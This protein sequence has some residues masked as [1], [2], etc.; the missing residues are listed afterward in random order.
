MDIFTTAIISNLI[1][2]PPPLSTTTT[3]PTT[4]TAGLKG[5]NF[6]IQRGISKLDFLDKIF[7][8]AKQIGRS[9]DLLLFQTIADFMRDT[10]FGMFYLL[11]L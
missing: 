2:P 3:T 1:L 10:D 5:L 11:L 4:P 8:S 9:Q 6:L 7:E